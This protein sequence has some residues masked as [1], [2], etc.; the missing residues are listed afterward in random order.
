M[1][2][3]Y[4]AGRVECKNEMERGISERLEFRARLRRETRERNASK[5]NEEAR[6]SK[7]EEMWMWW[8]KVGRI[9]LQR[10]SYKCAQVSGPVELHSRDELS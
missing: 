10:F 9:C 5:L 8:R 6:V 4:I 3:R 7:R 1:I 2:I